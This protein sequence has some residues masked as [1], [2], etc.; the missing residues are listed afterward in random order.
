[1]YDLFW[2]WVPSSQRVRAKNKKCHNRN[3]RFPTRP[4]THGNEHLQVKMCGLKGALCDSLW[5]TTASTV[6]LFFRFLF[7]FSFKVYF[8][9]WAKIT[10]EE[11]KSEG[12]GRWMGQRCMMWNPQRINKNYIYIYIYEHTYILNLNILKL[13]S[14]L[15]EKSYQWFLPV[16]D[17]AYSRI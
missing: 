8:V 11:G 6:R 16:V 13:F 15:K 7:F 14:L 3:Q 5:H 10:R 1:M 9:L 12:T 4:M 17:P 2:S